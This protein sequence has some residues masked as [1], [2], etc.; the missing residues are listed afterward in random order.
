MSESEITSDFSRFRADKYTFLLCPSTTIKVF[1]ESKPKSDKIL[2]II[3]VLGLLIFKDS[4]IEIDF[5]L[6]FNF[7]FLINMVTLIMK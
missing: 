4:I 7:Y 2:L 1:L 3:L 6:N 5:D